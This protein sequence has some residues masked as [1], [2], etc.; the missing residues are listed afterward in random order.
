[1]PRQKEG[2]MGADYASDVQSFIAHDDVNARESVAGT[3]FLLA[4]GLLS[5][6]AAAAV[7]WR[8]RDR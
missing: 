2:P 5:F 8:R 6:T 3:S 4:V 7:W 1:M